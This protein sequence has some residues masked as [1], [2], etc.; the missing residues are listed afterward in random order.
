MKKSSLEVWLGM[1][2][3]RLMEPWTLAE[4]AAVLA[5]P[6]MVSKMAS[7]RTM[8]DWMTPLMPGIVAVMSS[9]VLLTASEL[10]MSHWNS[11]TLTLWLFIVFSHISSTD[12]AAGL[13]RD[14]MAKCRAPW[15]CIQ[16][17]M[18]RPRP[19][20]PPAIKYVALSDSCKGTA[21]SINYK[22][23]RLVEGSDS[24]HW[25]DHLPALD[26]EHRPSRHESCSQCPAAQIETSAKP[27]P[28]SKWRLASYR[29]RPQRQEKLRLWPTAR[30]KYQEPVPRPCSSRPR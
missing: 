27:L 26:H 10:A 8:A 16:V 22:K 14:S 3:W 23:Y 30:H 29:I 9:R 24:G 15:L 19:P 13:E 12:P 1:S 11:C 5:S 20:I 25:I 17:A 4:T 28:T 7:R 18:T 6:V 21:A 2:S